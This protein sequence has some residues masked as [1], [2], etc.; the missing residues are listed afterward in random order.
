M[1]LS[2]IISRLEERFPKQNMESWDNV[3]LMIGDKEREI[4]KIQISLDVTMKVIEKAAAEGVDLIISHHPFIFSPI[5][6]INSDTLLGRKILKLIEN[7]I[8]VYSMHTNLDAT[9][10]GLN[11]LVG[12]KLGLG[13]GKIIDP[14]K[15]NFYKGEF[16]VS[17]A[18]KTEKITE[19][20]N[21]EKVS[22]K[23][24][25]GENQEKFV[26]MC[27]KEKL[28]SLLEKL[29][30]KS[31]TGE[32]YFI[33]QLENKYVERGIG[34]IYSLGKREK[35]TDIVKLVKDK[36]ELDSVTVSGYDIENA[37]IKK[38]AIVNGAG[39]SYWKKAK[40]MGADL[41][42][43][44]DLRYHEALDAKEEGMYILDAGHYESEQ[45]FYSIIEEILNSTTGTEYFVF[46]DEPV[47]KKM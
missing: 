2:E 41:L 34:R 18:E 6:D 5:K 19:E 26:I 33:Y 23:V 3:G 30:R 21:K 7:K 31:L 12:K 11:D 39:S 9:I 43:T 4:E 44:G 36:L 35:L 8:A 32:D 24:E 10:S 40:R 15:E 38:I 14:V 42:I 20:L 29:K 28:Y 46:N 27:E 17:D 25:K 47:L 45:F 22:F 16:Y 1:K 13:E 37:E